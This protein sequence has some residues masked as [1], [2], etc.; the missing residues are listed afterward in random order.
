MEL[1]T[2]GN[3][4]WVAELDLCVTTRSSLEQVGP[5]AKDPSRKALTHRVIA[6]VSEA[7]GVHDVNS[8]VWCPRAGF[9]DL[10]ATAGDDGAVKVW[11]V[12]PS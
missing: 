4:G 7:H 9:E 11:R 10:F 5:S 2:C 6:K 8:V 12:V 3:L 1:S